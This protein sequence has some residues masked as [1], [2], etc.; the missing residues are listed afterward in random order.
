MLRVY[1]KRT[2]QGTC[3]VAS[4]WP[5]AASESVSHFRLVTSFSWFFLR[6]LINY[7]RAGKLRS[8]ACEP[9]NHLPQKKNQAHHS[10]VF[11]FLPDEHNTSHRAHIKPTRPYGGKKNNTHAFLIF[12]PVAHTKSHRARAAAPRAPLRLSATSRVAHRDLRL[13]ETSPRP[14]GG[15]THGKEGE[16]KISTALVSPPASIRSMSRPCR[17]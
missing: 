4:A 8:R 12:P 16:A 7:Q 5:S 10:A 13:V 3:S 14:A 17:T 2:R 1:G 11:F 9:Y 6:S 15:N